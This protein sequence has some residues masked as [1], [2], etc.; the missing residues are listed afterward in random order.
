[1]L[2]CNAASSQKFT[3]NRQECVHPD[4]FAICLQL[5]IE[6]ES[7]RQRLAQLN[8]EYAEVTAAL[9]TETDRAGK[10]LQEVGLLHLFSCTSHEHVVDRLSRPS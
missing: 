6:L 10:A 7:S 4:Q 8:A 1:M 2:A 3:N 5:N 9:R